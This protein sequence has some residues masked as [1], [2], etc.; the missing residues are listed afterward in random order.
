MYLAKNSHALLNLQRIIDDACHYCLFVDVCRSYIKV[1]TEKNI[2]VLQIYQITYLFE[3]KIVFFNKQEKN[4]IEEVDE[5]NKE[6]TQL[7]S[8][9]KEEKEALNKLEQDKTLLEDV[10]AQLQAE[11][12]EIKVN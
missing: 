12:A 5:K 4:F 11:N 3:K 6:L 10:Q 9:S 8:S 2:L 1:I 7:R